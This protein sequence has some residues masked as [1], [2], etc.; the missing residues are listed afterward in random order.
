MSFIVV[1]NFKSN[2]TGP[3][4]KTW[5]TDV[6]PSAKLAKNLT[7]VL[8]PSFPHLV[9]QSWPANIAKAAQDVSPFPPGSYTGAVP[10]RT[11]KDLGVTYAIVGHSERRRHFHETPV[12]IANKITELLGEGITP[13]VCVTEDQLVPQF[14]ALDHSVIGQCIFCFEPEDNI[15]GTEIADPK[16]I[17]S[18]LARLKSLAPS[19]PLMYGGSVNERN[20]VSL[21][22]LKLD[23]VLVASASLNSQSFIAILT[24]LSHAL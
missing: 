9:T 6:S 8:A 18:V 14:A 12:E 11:L 24:G 2:Q 21:L 17:K 3:G 10:A 4:V 16:S 19:S 15:G 20:I 13:I 5:L 7:V 1:A 23:G 22:S